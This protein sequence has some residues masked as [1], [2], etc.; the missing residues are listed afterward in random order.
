MSAEEDAVAGELAAERFDGGAEALLV[1]FGA[2]ARRRSVGTE[3]AKR[4]IAAEDGEAGIAEGVGQRYEQ[5]RFAVCAC[6]VR[7]DERVVRELHGNVEVAV[8]GRFA[9]AVVF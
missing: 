3:L 9:W 8:N 7:E 4:Q 6:A 2:A 5:R 1:A